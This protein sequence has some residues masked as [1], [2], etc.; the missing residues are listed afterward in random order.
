MGGYP[1]RYLGNY[2]KSDEVAADV[3]KIPNVKPEIC[4]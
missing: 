3:S 2:K 1:W 4:A